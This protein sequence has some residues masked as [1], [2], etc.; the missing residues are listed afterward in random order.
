M[1]MQP[2]VPCLQ[3][4]GTQSPTLILVPRIH[5]YL[6]AGMLKTGVN[7]WFEKSRTQTRFLLSTSVIIVVMPAYVRT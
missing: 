5:N 2:V 6:G 7:K 3:W 1:F 4:V